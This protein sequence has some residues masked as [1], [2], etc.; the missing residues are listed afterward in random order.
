MIRCLISG[1]LHLDPVGRVSQSGKPFTTAKMRADSKDGQTAWCSLIAFGDEA[2]RL[3]GLKAGGGLSVSGR[4]EV[5]A[6]L[7]KNGEPKGGLS[8]V[9][10]DLVT[11]KAKSRQPPEGQPPPRRSSR[12]SRQTQPESSGAGVPFDDLDD[13]RP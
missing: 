2:E 4:C 9:V 13:W 1:T 5:Q 8:V 11:L 10:D 12:P 6:W 3:A 7:D